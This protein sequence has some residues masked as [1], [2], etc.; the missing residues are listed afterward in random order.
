MEFPIFNVHFYVDDDDDDLCTMM[1]A[2]LGGKT[3]A[4]Q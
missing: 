1:S 3:E 2:C 4:I